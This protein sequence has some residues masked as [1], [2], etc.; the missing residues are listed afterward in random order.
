MVPL[1]D[2]R[3][4]VL[5]GKWNDKSS[6]GCHLYDKEFEQKP[7]LFTWNNNPKYHLKIE[8]RE[9]ASVK[10]VLTRPEKAWKV[11]IGKNL[12]GCMIGF[13]VFPYGMTPAEGNLVNKEGRNF[14][15][16]NQ[17]DEELL[18]DPNPEGYIIMPTTYAAGIVGPFIISVSTQVDF[19]FQQITDN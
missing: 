6:G 16:W 12:V 5:V 18:L 13:Y 10:I 7:E 9:P 4:S 1:P 3:N 17:V 19:T 15:P 14:I 11:S 8:S 2:S